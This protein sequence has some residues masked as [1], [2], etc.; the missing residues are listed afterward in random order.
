MAEFK[1]FQCHKQ[2]HARPMTRGEYNEFRGWVI[3]ANENPADEGLLVVYDRGTP[4]E[5]VSWS[6]RGVFERGYAEL[7]EGAGM[8]YGAALAAM[9]RGERVT[10]RGWNGSGMYAWLEPESEFQMPS[11]DMLPMRPHY[12]LKTAQGDVAAWTPSTSDTLAEDWLIDQPVA[13]ASRPAWQERVLVEVQELDAKIVSLRSFTGCHLFQSQPECEQKR[14]QRQL[15]SMV[16]Y[17]ETLHQRIA[18]F[19]GVER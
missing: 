14:L 10:R 8:G 19:P 3:P 9:Q 11:G 2:V 1:L 6:P 5:Y 12:C 4:D 13:V 16:E 17:S 7:A 15:S 18:A